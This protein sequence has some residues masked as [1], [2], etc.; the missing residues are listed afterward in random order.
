VPASPDIDTLVVARSLAWVG[1]AY[2]D[3]PVL[4]IDATRVMPAEVAARLRANNERVAAGARVLMALGSPTA[5]AACI[6]MVRGVD[7]AVLV[8]RPGTTGLTEARQVIDVVGSNRFL[9]AI[10][11]TA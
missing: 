3:Q 6:P 7:A 2:L 4:V 9:G 11:L 1:H 10:T 8:V 5:R